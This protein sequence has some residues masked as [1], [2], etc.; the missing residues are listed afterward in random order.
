LDD[1]S[2]WYFT[3][4]SEYACVSWKTVVALVEHYGG[5][6]EDWEPVLQE[7]V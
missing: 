1:I 6:V 2:D 4:I 7:T 3:V 5:G